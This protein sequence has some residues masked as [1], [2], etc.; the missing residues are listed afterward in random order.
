MVNLMF[1]ANAPRLC[2]MI[3]DELSKET[4]VLKGEAERVTVLKLKK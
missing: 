3:M 2:R 4:V 1:G